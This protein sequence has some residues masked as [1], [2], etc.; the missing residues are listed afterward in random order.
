MQFLESV[1]LASYTTF[2]IGGPAQ[3]FAEATSEEDVTAAFAFAGR[4]GLAVFVLGG[5]SNLLVSDR[6]YAG[7]VLRV[8][9]RGHRHDGDAFH[10]AAGESWDAFVSQAV[11]LGYGGIEC[12]AGIPGTVGA[13]PVQNVG[14]YGQEVAETI[15]AVR[16]YDTESEQF[17]TLT[18]TEC[19]FAYR[20]SIFN[21]EQRGRY[22]VT[23]V[24]Y[25]LRPQAM[26]HLE[27]ADLQRRFPAGSPPSLEAVSAAVREIRHGKGMLIVPGEP[28]CRSAGSFFK[29]PVVDRAHYERIAAESETPVPSYPAGE[30]H[31]KL[32]AAWLVEQAGFQKGFGEGPAG[33]SSRHTLALVNRGGAKASDVLLLATQI[34][35]GVYKKFGVTLEMEPVV[36]A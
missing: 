15:T 13:T 7:L 19:G 6:G 23:E 22:V 30:D 4:R 12:L 34:L 17:V 35:Q 18:A 5:G 26:P 10:V 3:W 32:P 1:S 29:N 20:R 36:V 33:I 16:A 8:G 21:T 31:V 14:A 2:G 9:L 11:S 24:S 28:D 25:A 27:Y